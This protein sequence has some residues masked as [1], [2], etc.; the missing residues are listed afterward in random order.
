MS[1]HRPKSW[2]FTLIN[3]AAFGVCALIISGLAL[4]LVEVAK[5]IF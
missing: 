5:L 1:L 4:L 3:L 2:E